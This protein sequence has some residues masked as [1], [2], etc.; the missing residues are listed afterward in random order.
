MSDDAHDHGADEATARV[1]KEYD[2]YDGIVKAMEKD[3]QRSKREREVERV[4]SQPMPEVLSDLEQRKSTRSAV[5]DALND[6]LSE[7]GVEQSVSRPT[8]YR[9][10][11]KY[12]IGATPDE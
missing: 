4:F 12:D 7:A 3:R 6:R 11:D 2:G 10:L 9:W 1:L 8:L 5:L